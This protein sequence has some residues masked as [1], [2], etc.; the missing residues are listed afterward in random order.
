MNIQ[1]QLP[2]AQNTFNRRRFLGGLGMTAISLPFLSACGNGNSGGANVSAAVFS[3]PDTKVPAQYSG[4]TAVVLWSP[5]AGNNG[6]V[7]AQLI[8]SFN[9]SQ[10]EIYAEI[11][12]FDGYDG[13]SEKLTAGL[14]AKQVPELA[15]LSDVTWNRY[16]L[17]DTLEPLNSHHGEGFSP[18]TYHP[19]FYAEGLVRDESYWVP[20][21]RSTP[22]F[23][24]NKEIFSAAGLPDRAPT[25]W[26]EYRG[27]GQELSGLKHKGK[28]VKMRALTGGDDWYFSGLLWAFGGSISEGLDVKLDTP[29]S[30]AAAEFDRAMVH[31]D[32]SAYLAQSFVT[33]FTNGQVASITQ[34]TGGLTGLAKDA[35]FEFG[36]GFLPK[37]IKTGVPTGGGG[38][39]IMRN[40]DPVRKAAA[41]E[42]LKFLAA[43]EASSTWTAKTG[44]LPA[45]AAALTS[46]TVTS[47]MAKDPNYK[48]AVDQLEI[49]QGPDH[50]RKYVN[51]G[52]TEM[53]DV[54]QKLYVKNDSSENVMKAAA[55]N[56]TRGADSI[57][58]KYDEKVA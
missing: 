7:L 38:L 34:S 36:T 29:E 15:V 24:Y 42:L 16:F 47:L 52:I 21:A 41:V 37:G 31:D 9:E 14:Q 25:T 46:P 11:Q 32:K 56:L 39:S 26:D 55:K 54:I 19:R 27:W 53:K 4:R 57:R 6:D 51:N 10:T 50:V 28:S 30:I 45:T 58:A 44:Y 1:P 17:N 49:A 35:K 23:Y 20:F 5:W 3:Q 13:V 8:K 2:P 33:D 40:A 12:Q 18:E 22:L 43:E 48:V